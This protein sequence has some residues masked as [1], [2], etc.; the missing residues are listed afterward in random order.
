MNTLNYYFIHEFYA[1]KIVNP[2]VF[3]ILVNATRNYHFAFVIVFTVT[4]EY[5][6]YMSKMDFY[7]I[8]GSL[9]GYTTDSFSCNY[10]F[11]DLISSER[12]EYR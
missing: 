1:S 9:G 12:Y 2:F 6:P 3:M 8:L 7:R 5:V 10:F 4:R 11:F